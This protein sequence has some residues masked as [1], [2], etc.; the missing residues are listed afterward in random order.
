MSR[1]PNPNMMATASL[2]ALTAA[3]LCLPGL[4]LNPAQATEQEA[5][6][7]YGHY[8]E[9]HRNLY[10]ATSDFNPVEVESLL[11]SS[12][13]KLT[14][15]TKLSFNYEQ[16]TWGGATPVTSMPLAFGGNGGFSGSNNMVSGA[17]PLVARPQVLFDND[18]NPVEAIIVDGTESYQR[19]TQVVDT[20]SLASPETRKQ[21]SFN[22][23][24]EGDAATVE[25]GGGVSV[26]DDYVSGFGNVN[27]SW[28][29]NQKR[30]TVTT[31]L[32]YTHSN[33]YAIMDH[34]ASAYISRDKTYD[35]VTVNANNDAINVHGTRQDWSTSLALTQI[36]NKNALLE[37]S[38]GYTR[39]TGYME[40]PYKAVAVAF[41]DPLTQDQCS[42]AALGLLCG[43]VKSLLEQRP[44]ARDQ[45]TGNLRYVQH[46]SPLD[47]AVHLGYRIF[48][49]DWGIMSHTFEADWVQPLGNGWTFTPR[50]R[51]YSQA[52]ADFYTPY[53]KTMQATE[54]NVYDNSGR[55]IYID[56]NNP[57]N[58][59]SYIYDA[60]NGVYVD[61]Q[62]NDVSDAVSNGNLSLENKTQSFDRN[63]LPKHFSSDYRLAGYGAIS[64]GV[65]LSKQFAK[66]VGLD[67]GFEYYSHQSA[68]Q[69][70]GNNA[71]SFNDFDAWSATATLKV[72]LAAVS[73]A[74]AGQG[75]H[76]HHHHH[77][78]GAHAPAG[79]MFDHLLPK[80]GDMMVGYRYMYGSQGGD[81]LHG[82]HTI[83]NQALVGRGCGPNPCFVAPETM[84]MDMH[85]LDLMYAPTD[86]LTLML[87]PQFMNMSMTMERLR[88][89]EY[90]SLADNNVGNTSG[91]AISGHIPHHLQ[92][93]HETGG[94]G[95]LGMYALVKLFDNGSHHVHIATGLSAPTGDVNIELRRNHQVD[96]GFIHYGMQLGSGTWDFKPSLTYTGHWADFS[97]GTQANGT[98]R[99]EAKNQS[100][101]ALGDMLQATA[102]GGYNLTPWL[103]ASVRGVYT[104]QGRVKNQFDGLIEQF[105]P[106]DYPS[107]YGGRYWDVGFGLSAMVLTGDLMGN[108]L[109]VE[110]LQPVEDYAYGY[111]LERNGALTATWAYAF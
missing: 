49:D 87:M 1:Q 34:D 92:N 18:L 100:G 19:N 45:W 14:D 58:G 108:R 17:T 22:L 80:A 110:W 12:Q 82:T 67:L 56:S 97:W 99:M 83:G 53:L 13:F 2:Q 57:N 41:I 104:L 20:L 98:L 90:D 96:G 74:N 54:S 33:T 10:G 37:T 8:Q 71:N 88:S 63:K 103:T 43:E 16:D 47:A 95:D 3:A 64:G 68:L 73:L 60:D 52:S 69:L 26:E 48:S 106:M 38:L 66:G 39:S 5:T 78:H 76:A 65:T 28:N 89:S 29:F 72:D 44:D 15:R 91:E 32:S 35:P 27:S 31:G 55:E 107:N 9:G 81:M 25:A 102:W 21:G 109:S 51:Y 86:W 50:V 46:I 77:Q 70:G 7:S 111:Q 42:Q 85:M 105:G 40:N 93:G 94:F 59:I 11:G 79:V 75:S 84:S 24:Y 30:T 36:L 23:A 6:F 62:G 61:N 101:Y 4:V